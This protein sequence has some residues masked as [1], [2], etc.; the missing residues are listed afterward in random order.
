MVVFIVVL[1]GGTLWHLQRFLQCIKYII[2][3]FTLSTV[4]GVLRQRQSPNLLGSKFI[5]QAGS[6]SVDSSPKA[7]PREQKGSSLPFRAGY[8]NG[9]IQL[10]HT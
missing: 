10:S 8:R 5:R 2:L 1:S 6:D 4:A 7:E 9:G 3:E